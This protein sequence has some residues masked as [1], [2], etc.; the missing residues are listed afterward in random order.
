MK[1]FISFLIAAILLGVVL[2]SILYWLVKMDFNMAV[3]TSISGALPAFIIDYI[4][5]RKKKR[6][7]GH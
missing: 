6:I 3:I 1:I 7:A 2:F 5:E 4:K